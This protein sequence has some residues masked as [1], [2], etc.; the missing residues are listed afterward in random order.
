MSFELGSKRRRRRRMWKREEVKADVV[1]S[2][3]A[4]GKELILSH[5]ATIFAAELYRR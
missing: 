1:S 3:L 2:I 4:T 5:P